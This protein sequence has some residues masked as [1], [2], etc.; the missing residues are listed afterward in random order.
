MGANSA[1]L[2]GNKTPHFA[3]S[4]ALPTAVKIWTPVL[5]VGDFVGSTQKFGAHAGIV[6]HD[7]DSYNGMEVGT[8]TAATGIFKS[9]SAVTFSDTG[10]RLSYF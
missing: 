9:N 10:S 8:L 6:V 1:G 2:P 5:E 4:S 3:S 7:R